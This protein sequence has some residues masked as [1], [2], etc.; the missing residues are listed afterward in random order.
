M[1]SDEEL[2][3]GCLNNNA[4]A[5]ESFYK[6]YVSRMY[7]VCLRFARSRMEADDFLQEGFIKV[8]ANLQS[9]RNEG[10]LDGWIR[11][12]IIN[13]AIN[14]IK[15]NAKFLNNTEIDRADVLPREDATAL[16]SLC[17]EELLEMIAELPTGYRIVFNLNV[18]EGYT[19]KEIGSLLDI[20]EN[21]SK[22]Q[23]S[24]ARQALQK[25]I[26]ELQGTLN[27]QKI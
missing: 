1:Y 9:F 7:G 21:T 13:T 19:H 17:A 23:L 25:K 18:I 14:L 22:S 15:K 24:R 8:F 11:R 12:T 20:S 26:S 4:R 3:Q 27:E 16:D 2:I 10:S 6:H 5:Q